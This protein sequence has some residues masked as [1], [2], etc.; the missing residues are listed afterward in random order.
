MRCSLGEIGK[1][2]RLKICAFL[3]IGSSPIVSRGPPF[4]GKINPLFLQAQGNL[5]FLGLGKVDVHFALL[6]ILRNK[7]HNIHLCFFRVVRGRGLFFITS[8]QQFCFF[9]LKNNK[10][11]TY[12]KNRTE[13]GQKNQFL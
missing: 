3:V 10:K 13:R 7:M 1:H 5:R 12:V 6:C 2:G 8:K 4:K 11:T 9:I